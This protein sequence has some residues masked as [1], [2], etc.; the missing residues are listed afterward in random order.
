MPN[1]IV[2]NSSNIVG[3]DN[4][5]LVYNFPSSVKFDNHSIAVESVSINYSWY[6]L[7]TA[8]LFKARKFRHMSQF[9][10]DFIC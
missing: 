4:N 6:N 8:I 2:F 3:N 1:T 9:D 5:T 7:L 10:V